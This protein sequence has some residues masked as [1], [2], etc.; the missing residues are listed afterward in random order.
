MNW[1]HAP[2]TWALTLV[3]VSAHL[4]A[5]TLGG[6]HLILEGAF[7]PA[8]FSVDIPYDF[9]VPALLTPLSATLLHGGWIHL[10]VNLVMLAFC[11]MQVERLAG[12]ARLMVLYIVGAYAAA[13]AQYV[14]EPG[15]STPMIGASGA[16]SAVLGCYALRFGRLTARPVGPVP[17]IAVQAVWL[18][19]AW[20]ALQWA[21]TIATVNGPLGIATAAHVGGFVAG[22]ALTIPLVPNDQSAAGASRSGSSKR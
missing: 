8:R 12:P 13:A 11:G 6:P 14:A 21:I 22:L 17:A 3:T 15:S 4:A 5:I 10:I 20:S 18:A 19:L 1:R 7:L 2:A 16:I 9:A